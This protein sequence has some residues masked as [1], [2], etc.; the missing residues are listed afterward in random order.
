[1]E[2]ARCEVVKLGPKA[3]RRH[4]DLTP[5]R[6]KLRTIGR[7][8]YHARK[9][10]GG[11]CLWSLS[12]L[13]EPARFHQLVAAANIL[14]E[15]NHQVGLTLGSYIKQTALLKLTAA[16]EKKD[17]ERQEEV[18]NFQFMFE[19][20]WTAFVTSVAGK[21]Q[22]HKKINKQ[23]EIPL[24]SDLNL[25]SKYLKEKIPLTKDSTTL[26]KLC[27]S[28]LIMFNKRRPMEVAELT[29]TNY[30][31]AIGASTLDNEEIVNSLSEAEKILAKR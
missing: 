28:Y 16:G 21:Q 19:A 20:Y 10:Q 1:M 29:S 11:G 5:L 6:T 12:D 23:E 17:K 4:F 14:S 31:M 30:L 9:E 25:L 7:L 15:M 2:F 24:T 13:L 18:K 3:I 8:V 27:L 26:K 22:R